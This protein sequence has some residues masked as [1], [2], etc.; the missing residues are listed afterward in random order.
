MKKNILTYVLISCL[1]LMA[2]YE[3]K[4]NYD[5]ITPNDITIDLGEGSTNL[6]AYVGEEF[7]F[8]PK[9]FEWLN[10]QDSASF[11]FWWENSTQLTEEGEIQVLGRERTLTFTPVKT[12]RQMVQL[13]A[14][15]TRTGIITTVSIGIEVKSP[16]ERGWA[17]LSSENDQSII[18]LI[19][20]EYETI[21]GQ[22]T[23]IYTSFIDLFKDSELLGY[24]PMKIRQQ[25]T[26]GG[27]IVLVIQ[28]SGA[29]WLNG[30]SFTKE[31]LLADEFVG[32]GITGF[33][34]KDFFQTNYTGTV[35]DKNGYLYSRYVDANSSAFY[36]S[37]FM[38]FPTEYKGKVLKIE[39]FIR[40]NNSAYYG[41]LDK[42]EK[43]ILWVNSDYFGSGLIMGTKM[44]ASGDFLDMSNFGNANILYCAGWN[45]AFPKANIMLLYERDGIVYVQQAETNY[46]NRTNPVNIVVS[47]VTSK[48]FSG[49][50]YISENTV[51][52]QLCL[53]PYLFFSEQGV[54]YWYDLNTG[55]THRFYD[56]FGENDR[57]VAMSSNPQESELGL[58]LDTP[59]GSKF[60]TLDITAGQLYEKRKITEVPIPGRVVDLDYKYPTSTMFSNRARSFAWD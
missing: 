41:L 23:R 12:G 58:V 38:N 19:R 43:R 47:N 55:T 27:S 49:R 60:V 50:E 16:Y 39:S 15:D 53:R 13:C 54:V 37:E 11:E 46:D 57:V 24:K 9:K 2:C 45:E 26:S 44:P 48:V 22:K 36:I 35:L 1:L 8:T 21:E 52:Y 6:L 56:E 25:L 14:R 3:D 42:N 51:F 4:G 30:S 29:I 20:P 5:Y 18:S 17:V 40:V 59:G 31:V 32:G 10:P 33:S 28:E 34:P 7:S